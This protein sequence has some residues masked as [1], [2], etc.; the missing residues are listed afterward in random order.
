MHIACKA[1]ILASG[2]FGN[3]PEL[4]KEIPALLTALANTVAKQVLSSK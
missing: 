3:N 2:G 4:V 1:V